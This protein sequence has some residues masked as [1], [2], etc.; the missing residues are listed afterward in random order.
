MA[1]EPQVSVVVLGEERLDV[2]PDVVDLTL[3]AP[4]H[5]ADR[6]GQV[7]QGVRIGPDVVPLVRFGAPARK[8]AIVLVLEQVRLGAVAFDVVAGVETES[9]RRHLGLIGR[10]VG[11]HRHFGERQRTLE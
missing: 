5:P 1:R 11:D 4:V 9:A 8:D 7:G 3:E 6:L 10:E 2:R